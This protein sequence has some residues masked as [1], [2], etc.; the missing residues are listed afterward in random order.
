MTEVHVVEALRSPMGRKKGSLS[1]VHPVDLGAHVLEGLVERSGI[2]PGIVDDVLFGCIGQIGAQ[3]ANLARNCWLAAGLPEHVPAVT[4]DRQ[5]GSSQ[6]AVHFAAQGILAGG[7]DVAIAGGVE[8]MNTVPLNSNFEWGPKLG[9]AH[10]YVASSWVKHYG[11]EEVH[12][13]RAGDLIAEKWDLSRD[14]MDAFAV[15]SHHRAAAA[16]TEGRFDREVL[17]IDGFDRDETIRPDTSLEVVGQLRAIREGSRLTVGTASQIADGASAVLLAS[18]DA[19]ERLGLK[20]MGVIR[21]MTVV[22]SDPRLMLTGPIPATRKLLQRAG[23]G[24]DEIDLFECNEAF[25]AVVIAWARETGADLTRTNVNGG[26]IALGHALGNTGTRLLTTMVHEL[27]RR[28][29]R[30]GLQT[31]C[32]G[33]GL[34]NALLVERLP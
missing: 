22:G 21:A 17:P 6:Q 18:S 9:V 7:Y 13:F 27:E 20:S 1:E 28:D 24:I 34:A 2:D 29:A 8:S 5:C 23:V 25:A 16:W 33:G 12:Q 19:V 31:I 26:A 32:E 30:F 10:P 3:S 11:A 14:E 4:I 15:D